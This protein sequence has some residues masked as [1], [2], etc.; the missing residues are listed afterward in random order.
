MQKRILPIALI[1]ALLFS[2]FT[3]NCT[4]L[5]TTDIGSDLLPAVD[6]VHTFD[7]ILNVIT[8][9][10]LFNDTTI[11]ERDEDHA[12]GS[13]NNDPLFGK[14]TANVFMQLKPTFYPFY[15]GNE[16]DTLNG[17][18][19]GL[20]SVVLCLKFKGFWGD[21]TLP[22]HFEVHEVADIKF[23]DSV[24]IAKTINYQP[25]Y[26]GT[27]LGT[28][29]VDIRRLADTVKYADKRDY[30]LNQIRINLSKLPQGLAWSQALY[31]RDTL[32][33]HAFLSDSLFREFYHGLAVISTGAGANALTYINLAD[34]STKI[35]IHFRRKNKGILD[36]VYNSFVLNNSLTGSSTNAPSNTTNN[37]IRNRTGARVLSPN[38]DELYLQTSPGTYVNLNIPGLSTLSNRIVHRAEII[39]EQI[40]TNAILDGKLSAPNF[41]YIDLK[42]TT[43]TDNWKP[44]Y[45]DLNPNVGYDPDFKSGPYFPTNGVDYTYFGGYVRDKTDVFGAPIK[46]Y[47]FNISRY[48][49]EIVTKHTPNYAL[50]LFSPYSFKYPQYST[51]IIPYSNNIASGRVRIGSGTNPNYKLRLRIIYSKL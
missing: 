32:A 43:T 45:L 40:P 7:T 19:A 34:T 6:N 49:Q 29:D 51:Q 16:K 17:F 30:S 47:N 48:V 27:I 41:L 23:R 11:I 12:L 15:L 44:I 2:L 50:R 39:V 26:S 13:I 9:Q 8:T 10:N 31:N 46:Y 21:S 1:A 14:T 35:E 18:G 42:D 25:I 24:Y 36:T 38:S 5:D 33:G 20:D 28:A 37:I 3:W 4:K 22:L